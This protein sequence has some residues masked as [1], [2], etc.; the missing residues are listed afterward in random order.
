[1]ADRFLLADMGGTNTRIAL[2]DAAGLRHD[3]VQ[4]F[5]NA[6]FPG[7]APLFSAYLAAHRPGPVT[8]VCAGV[9]G[10]V[11]GG[12]AKLTNHDWFIDGAE[13]RAATGAAQVHLINDLQ[14][15]GHSLD[16]LPE[17]AVQTLFPGAPA[18]GG[19]PRLVL[20]LGTG[21][22]VAVVHRRPEGLFVPA[23]ESGH[24]PLPHASGRIGALLDHLAKAQPHLPVEAALSG[25]GLSNIHAFLAGTTAT[26]AAIVAGAEAGQD[27]ARASLALFAELLGHVAGSFALHHLPIGGVF[28]T[29]ATARAVAPHLT[30]VGFHAAFT[31]RGPYS[32]IVRAIPVFAIAGDSFPLL[33]CARYLRQQT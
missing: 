2:A 15:Q 9:A 12:T 31:A 27:D 22:N 20:N 28:L 18:P 32:D 30:D 6:D 23:A 8:A 33:G 14:A 7:P 29:G 5:R 24:S 21:C 11:Q 1:M 4:S 16:D 26:P 19:A 3:T 10:P 13:L 17:D 25:P